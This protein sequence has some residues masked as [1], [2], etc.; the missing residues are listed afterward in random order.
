VNLIRFE[1]FAYASIALN[2]ISIVIKQSTYGLIGPWSEAVLI[3]V[4]YCSLIWATVRR[5]KRWAGRIYVALAVMSLAVA[6]WSVW[7]G[8]FSTNFAA[9][10]LFWSL[11]MIAVGLAVMASYSLFA[12]GNLEAQ[13]AA[14]LSGSGRRA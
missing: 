13:K 9:A 8:E 12:P 3:A 14:D 4:I 1:R 6:A 2:V 5:G 11:Q 10:P 7:T